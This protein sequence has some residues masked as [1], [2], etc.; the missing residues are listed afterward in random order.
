MSNVQNFAEERASRVGGA[1][2]P[3]LD[4]D[5]M[6][7]VTSEIL[8]ALDRVGAETEPEPV[9]LPAAAQWARFRDA[10]AEAMEGGLYTVEDL[11]RKLAAGEAYLWPGRNAAVV[12]ERVVYPSGEAV[13]QTLW[14]VGDLAEVLALAPGIEATGRLLGCSSMLVEGRKGWE[15]VLKDHGY[16]PWSVTLR[17]AL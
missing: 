8:D 6:D 10:F 15:R 14:A 1:E 4:N 7:G 17:K 12:A 9:L 16:E 2:F 13:L 5:T 3:D 11:E